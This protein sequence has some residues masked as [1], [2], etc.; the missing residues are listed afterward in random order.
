MDIIMPACDVTTRQL[1]SLFPSPSTADI[2]IGA[3]N[4]WRRKQKQACKEERSEAS[5]AGA[6]SGEGVNK[7][8]GGFRMA[9]KRL[10]SRA[11]EQPASEPTVGTANA[12]AGSFDREEEV[13]LEGLA[14]GMEGDMQRAAQEVEGDDARHAHVARLSADE[15]AFWCYSSPGVDAPGYL[16][17][18]GPV[19]LAVGGWLAACVCDGS[20]L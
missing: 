1:T 14:R 19:R 9:L 15:E 12:G 2:M 6:A 7:R 10:G 4:A 3:S 11:R 20:A 16:K 18:D 13:E 8:G 5:V 17:E